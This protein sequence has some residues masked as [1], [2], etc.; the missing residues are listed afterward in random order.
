MDAPDASNLVVTFCD[1]DM[2]QSFSLT[3]DGKLIYDRTGSCVGY[4]EVQNNTALKLLECSDQEARFDFHLLNSSY[5][6]AIEGGDYL[7]MTPMA[8][9]SE[10]P[11][12]NDPVGITT[13]N[14]K[15]S[16][17]V[18][19]EESSFQ[20]DRRLIRNLVIPPGD[21]TCDFKM[22]GMNKLTALIELLPP[23]H[24]TPC[25][26]HWE[27]VTLVV[28]TGRRPN[29]LLR[30]A[31]SVRDSFGYD[32]PIACFDDGPDDYSEEIMG[33]IAQYPLL[34]YV[35]GTYNDYGIAE[36]RNRALALVKTKYFL[37]MDDDV[38]MLPTTDLKT[39]VDILDTTDVTVVGGGL[40]HRGNIAGLL[41]FGYFNGTKRKLGLFPGT[42]EKLNRTVPNYPACFQC[43]LNLNLFMG[44]TE[45]VRATGGW[46][47]DLKILEHKDIYIKMKAAGLKLAVC[48]MVKLDHVPPRKGDMTL[49]AES[50]W[51]KR[52]RASPPYSQLLP[53]R[54]L[55]Q[56]IFQKQER[57]VD[58]EGNIMY[59]HRQD[60]GHC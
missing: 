21:A 31:Q 34:N 30:L 9:E 50:Y 60:S 23:H 16:Q 49:Q 39:M 46:D 54:Y 44:K 26:K 42:C 58:E 13:C 55:V 29:L 4:R 6:I 7:C 24:V 20:Q 1:P 2:M 40:V 47:P 10:S 19:L 45:P 32:L 35:I 57:D 53:N 36:G 37:L 33:K 8:K 14:N 28:K 18:L 48:K 3:S 5:L 25:A 38:M 11:C 17:M 22:C 51:G 27:C 41:K 56:S 52:H 15:A 12:L 59:L 43:D